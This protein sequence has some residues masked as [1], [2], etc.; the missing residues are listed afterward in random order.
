MF[1]PIGRS[2]TGRR[3]CR[4]RQ[5]SYRRWQRY[6]FDNPW[7]YQHV[8]DVLA[9]AMG[10]GGDPPQ[11]FD[12][13]LYLGDRWRRI[14]PFTRSIIPS[15][16][17]VGLI[18]APVR[19]VTWARISSTIRSGRLDYRCRGASRR[20]R[21]TGAPWPCRRWTLALLPALPRGG[22]SID[23]CHSRSRPACTIEFAAR[24]VHPPVKLYWSDGGI[25]PPRPDPLPDDVRAQQ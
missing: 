3:D 25:Y 6:G 20:L 9:G 5:E 21:R 13:D 4:V 2:C 19:S 10:R 12:W 1:G 17:A 18:L 23:R 14:C 11:G 15:T 16:G 8:Q 7:T 22:C 24:G